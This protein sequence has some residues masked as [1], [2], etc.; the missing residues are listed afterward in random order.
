MIRLG[1]FQVS[2]R[3][4]IKPKLLQLFFALKWTGSTTKSL[5]VG[6]CTVVDPHHA[7]ADPDST[8]HPAADLDSVFI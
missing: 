1:R 6:Q 7:D 3:I 5:S 4:L 8:Y 2:I